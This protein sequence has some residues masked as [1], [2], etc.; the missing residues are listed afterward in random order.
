MADQ[1]I[2]PATLDLNAFTEIAA[3]S[4]EDLT[5]S[6]DGIFTVPKDGKFLIHAIDAAG[7]AVVTVTAGDGFLSGQGHVDSAAMTINLHNFAVI[8]SARFKWLTQDDGVISGDTGMLGKI[9]IQ[10]SANIKVA[11]I[12]LP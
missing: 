11:V 8:E 9:R 6:N 10:T 2:T 5:S 4:Y 1:T 3:G 7:S 12:V